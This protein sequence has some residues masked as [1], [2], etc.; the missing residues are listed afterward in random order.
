MNKF[1]IIALIT[2]FAISVYFIILGQKSKQGAAL[3]LQNNK[4]QACPETPNCVSSEENV[5]VEHFVTPISLVNQT[6]EQVM[7]NVNKAVLALNGV[8]EKRDNHYLAATFTSSL[9]HYVDDFEVRFDSE[10]QLVHFRSAS[11]VGKSDFGA[12]RKRVEAIKKL[13]Q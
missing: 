9:F 4:L 8:V 5:D 12:N 11:R 3:G 1:L 2:V 10:Q 7:E 13:L 6:P